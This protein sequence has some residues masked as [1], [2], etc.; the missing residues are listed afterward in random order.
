MAERQN[1][2]VDRFTLNNHKAHSV[3]WDTYIGFNKESHEAVFCLLFNE[4]MLEPEQL[5]EL[6]RVNI[7]LAQKNHEDVLPPLAW[8]RFE[9]RAYLVL[10]DFGKPLSS[11]SNLSALK[12]PE[13]L[14]IMRS[15]LRALVFADA[16]DVHFHG[17]MHPDNIRISLEESD[18]RLGFFGYPLKSMAGDVAKTDEGSHLLAYF[19]PYEL[20]D[21]GLEDSQIDMYALGLIILELATARRSWDVLP[22]GDRNDPDE[23]R[24]RLAEQEHLPLPIQELLYRLLSP[25]L[26]DRYESFQKAL[27]DVLQLGG[28]Q[29]SGVAFRTFVL[30]TLIN[31]RFKLKEEIAKGRISSIYRAIDTRKDEMGIEEEKRSLLDDRKSAVDQEHCVVKLIDLR[32]H[33]EYTEVFHTRFRTLTNIHHKNLLNVFDVGV[34]FENGYIAMEAGLLSLEQL[35]IKRGTLPISDAGRIVFQL[36]KSLEALEYSKIHY[37]GGIKPSNVFL[38]SDLR[39]VKLGDTLVADFLMRHGNLNF[40]GAEYLTPEFIRDVDCDVRTDIYQMGVLFF[41]MLVGHAPFSFKIEDEIRHDHLG[42]PAATRVEPALISSEVKDILLRMLEKQPLARYQTVAELRDDLSRLLG[43]DKKE[44]VEIPNLFFDFAE[45]SM[46]GKN[47]R[48]KSEETLAIR[49]PAVNNRA[50]GAVAL[51]VGEGPELGDAAKSATKALGYLRELMFHPGGVSRDFALLQKNSPEEFITGVMENLNQKVYRDA[52]GQSKTRKMGISAAVA[53]VQENTLYLQHCGEAQ[54]MILSKGELVDINEDKWTI[55]DEQVIGDESKALSDEVFERIG[56]GERARLQMLK[57][58]L[59]DGDQL[60][61]L[62]PSLRKSLSISEIKELAT[63]SSDPAQTVDLIRGDAIRRR[64]EGTISVVLLSIGNVNVFADESISH[65]KKGQLARNFLAQGDTY[66]NDGKLD[67][68]IEQFQQALEINPNFAIIHHQLGVAYVRKGLASYA[69]SCFER[70]IE[71]NS[72]LASS[73][74]EK[75]RIYE[76]QRKH[77]E[78]LPLLRRAV[79]AGARDAELYARLG[80]ELLRARNYEQAAAYCSMALELD[81][82]HSGAYRDRVIAIKRSRSIDTRM[83]KMIGGRARLADDNKTRIEQAAP[84]WPDKD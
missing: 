78:I 14:S 70:A 55:P 18:V 69:L 7:I 68:A 54:V 81:A 16:N 11:Y 33:K 76:Q 4:E 45:L 58:R 13:L 52:F 24:K 17:M 75:A 27:D 73:Y 77:K 64:L 10:P 42:V 30:D 72:K 57:R 46:I 35:L 40:N 5:E 8:G 82:G 48:E 47:A 9:D 15:L 1:F 83:L 29:D 21:R 53:V 62:S 80:H 2:T 36:C 20:M 61:L 19:P 26:E 43:Y 12:S 41:E 59:Q 60:I 49:L 63:S 74:L 25:T 56:F 65:S 50:R 23:L 34:H 79:D 67:E 6:K 71:L 28:E 44:Q 22:A 3:L 38:T 31:G 32:K 39:T 84:E 37:H 66:L 51:L